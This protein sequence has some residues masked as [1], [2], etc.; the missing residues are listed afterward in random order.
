MSMNYLVYKIAMVG[1]GGVGK[2]TYIQRLKGVE[3][4]PRYQPTIGVEV[5]PI[6]LHTN[7]AVVTFNMWDTASQEKFG[8]F[9]D[10]YYIGMDAAIIM[11]SYS[12]KTS[13]Q[14]CS[15][16]ERDLKRVNTNVPIVHVVNKVDIR[17]GSISEEYIRENNI[18]DHFP[19]SA[20]NEKDLY[21]P[22]LHL[23]KI[24]MNDNDIFLV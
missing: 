19:I 24:L 4:D 21:A 5:H 17:D 12:S 23:A 7:K 6:R 8:G 1:N 13:I 20:K 10:G 15:T 22:L 11:A 18:T 2:S 14:D 3:F 9:R 16:W